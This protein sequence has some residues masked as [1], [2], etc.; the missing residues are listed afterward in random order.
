MIQ[1]IQSVYLLI[2]G[3]LTLLI[4]KLSIASYLVNEIVYSL[5]VCHITHPEGD[6]ALIS[7]IPMA[8]LPILSTFFSF[9]ALIRFNNRAFQVKL[10]KINLLIL[11]TL[12]V[13]Q[14]IYFFK[15]SSILSV[16]GTPQFGAILPLIAL[17]LVLMANRAIKKDD[18]LIRSA[19][20][21]R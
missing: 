5:F 19:D 18:D 9:F 14:V 16:K 4:Y 11:I 15:V 10:G 21:I 7:V 8:I 17:I 1:R 13:V 6:Q 20:R 12:L 2:A 3:I